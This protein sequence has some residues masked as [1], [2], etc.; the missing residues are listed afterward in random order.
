MPTVVM[1]GVLAIVGLLGHVAGAPVGPIPE[2]SRQLLVVVTPAWESTSGTLRRYQRAAA[3]DEWR[4]VGAEV[5]VVVG[6]AGLGWGRGLHGAVGAGPNKREGDGRAPA[7]A[8]RLTE[9]FGYHPADSID[10]GLPYLQSTPDLECVDDVASNYYNRV[11]DRRS[12]SPD[13]ESHE[14][15]RRGDVLYRRGVVVG[16]NVA[17]AAPGRGSCIFLHVWR[18]PSSTTSGC[19]AMEEPALATAMA[20]LDETSDPVLVQLPLREYTRRRANWELPDLP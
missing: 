14:E 1:G 5:Q 12:V 20:W 18:G 16:H 8:F 19:T 11:L 4:Q 3:T 10:T 17:P 6:R 13:W 15:M 9:A 2:T 7:G